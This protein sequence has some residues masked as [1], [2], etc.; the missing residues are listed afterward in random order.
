[1]ILKGM[2]WNH[3]RGFDPMVATAREFA[4]KN[5]GV[6]VTWEKRSLQAFADFSVERLAGEYDLL[7]IDHPH[8]GDIAK[9]KCLVPLDQV[10]RDAEL[11]TLAQQS[12]GVSHRSYEYDGHQWALAI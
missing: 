10:G 4:R 3:S 7:V 9:S 6:E 11:R 1:M 5:P 12:L 8:V 2:T